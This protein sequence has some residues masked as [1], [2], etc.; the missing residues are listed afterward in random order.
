MKIKYV[1]LALFLVFA[2]L[3]V[4]L[5][6]NKKLKEFKVNH[7]EK[8]SIF[9]NE[10]FKFDHGYEFESKMFSSLYTTS[11]GDA[12]IVYKLSGNAAK[13]DFLKNDNF[14][15]GGMFSGYGL[16]NGYCLNLE[17]FVP[18]CKNICLQANIFNE[19]EISNVVVQRIYSSKSRIFLNKDEEQSIV[20]RSEN[21]EKIYLE[22]FTIQ[23][24][25]H[26]YLFIINPKKD[27]KYYNSNRLIS[28]DIIENNI[29][30]SLF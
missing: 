27:F 10:K 5:M 4:S 1:F 30:E 7:D 9:R 11:S 16:A 29:M 24:N 25:N 28:Q 13:I 18:N 17:D 12:L 26:T 21:S 23:K 6:F 22:F 14:D 20:I 2:Y 8:L 19:K 15:D 3:G